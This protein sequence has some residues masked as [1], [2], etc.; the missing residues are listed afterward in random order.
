MHRGATFGQGRRP[1]GFGKRAP[2]GGL[3]TLNPKVT[4]THSPFSALDRCPLLRDPN[5]VLPDSQR[6]KETNFAVRHDSEQAHKGQFTITTFTWLLSDTIPQHMWLMTSSPVH[7]KYKPKG[8]L[9]RVHTEHS[10]R[11]VVSYYCSL[12]AHSVMSADI[13][14]KPSCG[15]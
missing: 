11:G 9:Q 12:T 7:S 10:S 14:P 5:T 6:H 2:Y 13:E 15:G 1:V 4:L 8:P 3:I